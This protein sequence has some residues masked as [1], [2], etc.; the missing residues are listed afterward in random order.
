MRH[1]TQLQIGQVDL[2]VVVSHPLGLYQIPTLCSANG[3]LLL[4]SL[5]A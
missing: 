1:L 2:F 3:H 4:L 5:N